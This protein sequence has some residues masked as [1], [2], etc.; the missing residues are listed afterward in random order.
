LARQRHD[1]FHASRAE[2]GV[3]EADVMLTRLKDWFVNSPCSNHDAQNT[4]RWGMQSVGHD[5]EISKKLHVAVEAL[6]NSFDAIHGC[7]ASF[8]STYLSFVDD[9]PE[10]RDQAYAFWT[11]LSVDHDVAN[12][13]ADLN[14]R[15]ESGRLLASSRRRFDEDLLQQ[16]SY[17]L[18]SVCRF[19]SSAIRADL[20]SP[21]SSSACASG[22]RSRGGSPR[23]RSI[24][25]TASPSSMMR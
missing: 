10:S 19:K 2:E 22:L 14:L 3:P 9:P 4:L 18:V 16:I 20:L 25:F 7:M 11:N 21:L 17:C 8:V 23:H 13:L 15:W 12:V 6:R 24:G 5:A 1:L